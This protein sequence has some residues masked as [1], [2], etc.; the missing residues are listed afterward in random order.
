MYR[1][2]LE[3]VIDM[4]L[5]GYADWVR[6]SEVAKTD[7]EAR[8]LAN[9]ALRWWSEAAAVVGMEL[10][11]RL[12]ELANR[13]LFCRQYTDVSYDDCVASIEHDVQKFLI[14][15]I[16]RVGTDVLSGSEGAGGG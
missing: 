8:I 6:A 16:K 15:L 11:E 2:R 9:L 12:R 1:S 3:Q 13:L 4:F 14:E 10:P 7:E 5:T